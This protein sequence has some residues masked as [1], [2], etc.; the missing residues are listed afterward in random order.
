MITW[1]IDQSLTVEGP[2]TGLF[3]PRL[4]FFEAMVKN[5]NVFTMVYAHHR[6][7]RLLL[8]QGSYKK[9]RIEILTNW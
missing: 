2:G 4:K 1:Y 6:Q 7:M 5:T 8:L 9:L 3:G